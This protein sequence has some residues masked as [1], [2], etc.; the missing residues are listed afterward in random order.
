MNYKETLFFIGKCLTINHEEH[1]KKLVENDLKSN[2]VN[3]DNV[4][5]VSTAHFVF[6]ALYSNLKKADFLHYLPT[7]LV[8]YMEH[9][10]DLNRERN[11][12]ILFQAKEINKLLL[13]NNIT[14]IFLKGTG[15]LLEALYDNIA[16]R[17]IGDIDFLVA[18]EDCH[19]AFK[20]LEDA[21]YTKVTDIHDDHRHLARLTH[22]E[23]IAAVEIH[24]NMLRE[25]KEDLFNY[26]TVINT[27]IKHNNIHLLSFENQIKLTVFSKFINDYAYQT[28]MISLRPAYD[29]YLQ[30]HKID[31][32][33]EEKS[34]AKELYAGIAVYY[35]ILNIQ[36]H[37]YSFNKQTLEY[38][39]K[40]IQELGK[41]KKHKQNYFDLKERLVIILRAFYKKSHFKFVMN[42]ITNRKWYKRRLGI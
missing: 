20:L 23:K 14:P 7:D 22:P 11:E 28:K 40:A 32:A 9:I 42:R 5:K 1:N 15:N 17:M 31:K 36:E 27:N 13:A 16:E 37:L 25:A 18:E 30:Q 10:S 3:W 35:R 26:A 41:S 19:K 12:Q 21:N 2:I 8:A 4:V 6:P 38:T 39:D 34:L 29:F 24:K 33:V